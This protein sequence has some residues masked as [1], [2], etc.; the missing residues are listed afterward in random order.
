MSEI[1]IAS[2]D[3]GSFSAYL[4]EPS[5]G[6]G[7]GV[8]VI[9]EIF[10]INAVMRKITDSYAEAGYVALAPDLFWRQQPGIQ[11]SD[12][13]EEEWNQ[14]L[15]LYQ[16][17]DEN[18][19]IEDLIATLNTLKK[20]PTCTG[21]VGSV[22]FCLGGKLAYLM[23][24]RSD[25][26]CNISYYGV[27]I[28]NNLDEAVNIKKPLML[29]IA[30]KDKFVNAETQAKI[31]AELSGN[32]LVTIYT[33]PN[34]DHAFARVGSTTYVEEVAKIANERSLEFFKQHLG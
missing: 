16:G 4:A 10:G 14:A 22:G 19:G 32:P 8:I 11:L 13:T 21:K 15:A 27:G 2:L 33:Y 1:S 18:K 29:H 30:E 23:A 34:V 12:S 17:F 20:L 24:T 6:A 9:Q 5:S 7:A 3:G 31:K 26:D 28:E 25:A